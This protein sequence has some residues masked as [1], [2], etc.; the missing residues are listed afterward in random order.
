[1][2][3]CV[4][5]SPI[6]HGSRGPLLRLVFWLS[7]ALVVAGV[8]VSRPLDAQVRPIY[9]EGAGGLV[10]KLQRLTTTASAMHTGAHPD[11][12][13]S[14]LIARL[15]RGDHARVAYL[16]LNRGEGG[17]N[18]FGP[19]YYEAL[20]VLRT[21]E[22]LQ[23]RALDGGEQLFTRVV[24]FGF[25]VNMAETEGKWGRDVVL[26][27]MV[28]AIRLHRPL[29]VVSRFSGTSA[30]GHG[31]H[32]L[33]GHLTPVAVEAAADP[34]RFPEHLSEG[35][36][37][38]QARKLYVG[39]GF[40]PSPGT[41]PTMQLQTGTFDAALGRTYFEIAM[42][43]RTQHKT[44]EMGSPL[45]KGPMTSNLRLVES[46]VTAAGTE[47]SVFD[48]I[49]V[50][51][52]GLARLAGLP[53]GALASELSTMATVASDALEQLDVRRPAALLPLLAR[54]LRA[55]QDAHDAA[56]TVQASEDARAE[57]RFLLAHKIRQYEDAMLHASGVSIDAV[58][59]R[60]TLVPGAATIVSARAFLPERSPVTVKALEVRAGDGW[61]VESSEAPAPPAGNIFARLFREQPTVAEHARVTAPH[62]ARPTQPYWLLEPARNDVFQWSDDGPKSV[63]FGP[64]EVTGRA[65]LVIEDHELVVDV[66]VQAR[67][68]DR[69]RGELRRNLHV[70]PALSVSITPGLE[71]V[72]LSDRQ[73]PREITVR[74]EN[75]AAT[76]MDG[77]VTLDVPSGWRLDPARVPVSIANEG[78]GHTARFTVR[79]ASDAK[80][81][82]YQIAAR[83]V[84]GDREYGERMRLLVYPHIQT[85]RI[86]E[87]A[88]V[89]VQVIDLEVAPLTLG[90]IMGVDDE[91]ADAL[92]LMGVDV[93]LLTP[94]DLAAGDLSRFDTIM[95]GIRVSDQR[96]DFVANINRLH[97]FVRAGGTLI[98]QEQHAPYVARNL[99]PFPGEIGSRVTD[100]EAPITILEPEH[101][102]FTFP[103][104]ITQADFD[105]WVQERNAYGFTTWDERYTP[106]LESH[107]P[108]D[109]EQ[110]G[111]LLYARMGEGH[112]VY[113]AYSW[114]RQLPAGVPGAYR[115]VANLVSLSKAPR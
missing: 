70:V 85:H 47:T 11:D 89:D 32:Q 82:A 83:A 92:R 30:D 69:V 110:Q 24:D 95:A 5:A 15:A 73:A 25:T 88:T 20:G 21:E 67:T 61:R 65:T 8:W 90:Y 72:K 79:P 19:D 46:S 76:A 98:V 94:N 74:V 93:T 57:A 77:Y 41:E 99:A 34:S 63:P 37:P 53:D 71:I 80:V 55:A 109:P 51:I 42:E 113:T 6:S 31:H 78:E 66:P 3:P 107:D 68:V 1:M 48:G 33:A 49:D 114:F 14:A 106:L 16:S 87:P 108:W 101:P 13:D 38:W 103:N 43:G 102:V 50:S 23:A 22:L 44:Q 36:R 60:E 12:E 105:G 104:R 75:L 64:P 27:D 10:Q 17:Q 100:E 18:V 111:G 112:Y 91:V 40:R 96:P 4:M 2:I 45:S 9:S 115:I 52:E 86:Y 35:L 81:S 54:G 39:Q 84:A 97:D 7:L 59:Q 56:A 58:A 28:R 62:T 26:G 29:V